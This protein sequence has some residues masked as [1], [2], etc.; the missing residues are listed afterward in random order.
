MT[1]LDESIL[2]EFDRQRF[3]VISISLIMDKLDTF[4]KKNKFLA[5]MIDNRNVLLS[6]SDVVKEVK[7]YGT[8]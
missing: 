1:N 7:K 3:N 2:R 5:F 6:F 8:S 4:E